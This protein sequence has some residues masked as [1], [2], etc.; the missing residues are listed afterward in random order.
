[1]GAW[2]GG[3]VL[4]ILLAGSQGGTSSAGQDSKPGD[5]PEPKTP[6]GEA[7]ALVESLEARVK[8]AQEDLERAQ[9]DL[10]RAREPLATIE[11]GRNPAD[12]RR[13]P[14]TGDLEG[15][16]RIAGIGGAREGGTFVK[17]PYDQYK[18]M[19][20]GHYL[21]PSFNRD[22]G[23]ILRSGDGTYSLKDG[24]DKARVDYSNASDLEA[25][26]GKDYSGT[27]HL[28]GKKCYHHG[29]MPNGAVF[30]EL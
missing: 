22:T 19:T 17:P 12:E 26:V 21:W 28:E 2:A 3:L 24:N 5:G 6:A 9:E 13:S 10:E 20:S 27:C 29:T 4:G 8:Q 7:R 30:D 23:E 14:E 15:V 1:M 18:I 25:I 16:W 11:E